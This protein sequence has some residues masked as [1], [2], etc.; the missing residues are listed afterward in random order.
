MVLEG[1]AGFRLVERQKGPPA[2]KFS[3]KRA[4]S[5]RKLII[6]QDLLRSPAWSLSMILE[7]TRNFLW[8]QFSAMGF[9]SP[10]GHFRLSWPVLFGSLKPQVAAE[11]F[12]EIWLIKT[13][14]CC[15]Y[16][17]HIRLQN[18]STGTSLEVQWWRLHGSNA[19]GIGLIPG[20]GTKIPRAVWQ[21]QNPKT[22]A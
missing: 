2:E 8:L 10:W 4:F 5:C 20:Q 3:F 7:H 17:V 14:V 9:S 16:K 11:H 18:L 22:L 21:G 12:T 19:E 1:G 15:D 6:K 13:E